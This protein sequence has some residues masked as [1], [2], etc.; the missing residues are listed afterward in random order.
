MN[1]GSVIFNFKGDTRDL[2][3]KTS[4]LD[5]KLGNIGKS[6]GSAFVKGTAVTSTAIAGLITAGVK[7]YADLEQNIGGIETLF[8]ESATEIQEM[9]KVYGKSFDQ[10]KKDMG[11]YT[12]TADEVFYNAQQ[13]YKTAGL[14]ANQYME[15]VMSFSASLKQALNGDSRAM[16]V[17]SDMAVTDMADNANK[18][19]TS[20]EMIQNAYQGFAKQNYTML[21]NLKLGYGGTKSEMERLLADASK[22][23]GIKYDISNLNDVF[24]AIHVIQGELKITGTTAKEAEETITGSLG[25]LKGAFANFLSGAGG[26]D[27][28]I[29][30]A[31]TFSKNVMNA[32]IE[33]APQITQGLVTLVNAL[34]PQ[35]PALLEP[36]LPVVINGVSDILTGLVS[37]FPQIINI[38][39][40][41]LPTLVNLITTNLPIIMTALINGLVSIITGLAEQIPILLPQI[42][43]AI[44]GI[45]PILLDNLPL[46]INAGF[47]LLGGII[48][49]IINSIPILLGRVGEIGWSLINAFKNIKLIDIGKNLLK[50]LWRGIKNAKDWLIDKIKSLGKTILKSIKGIFGI[51]SPSTEF[52]WIGKMNMVGLEEGM[53]DMK[54]SLQSTFDGMF[55][56]SPNLYGN[57]S[58]HLSPNVNVSVYSNTKQDPLGRMVRDIKTFAGGSKNDYN[59]VGA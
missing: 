31:T 5:S 49:G 16:M 22:I 41:L 37:A 51:H 19:G 6:I 21:D 44:L 45:I 13:A 9:E 42:I 39:V 52:A 14:S 47:Q 28:V 2:D 34:L 54:P 8:E 12:S 57:T 46:L 59:Y 58:A 32:V 4:G 10:I 36:L 23:S 24:Q 25:S 35:I 50:G 56:L 3:K 26:V 18:M 38:L 7:E 55:D 48:A 20:M 1:G 43:D 53:E 17:T 29:T 27:A 11:G 40:G 15:T 30:T 33:L